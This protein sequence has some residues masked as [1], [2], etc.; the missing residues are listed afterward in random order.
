MSAISDFS[1][2]NTTVKLPF[3]QIYFDKC[4]TLWDFRKMTDN[5]M[6]SGSLN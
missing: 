6:L 5:F 4:Q 2:I 1:L 3:L